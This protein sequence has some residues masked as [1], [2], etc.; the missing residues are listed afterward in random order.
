MLSGKPEDETPI[1]GFNKEV[2]D[3]T[4][5]PRE[6]HCLP[7]QH[8]AA[9]SPSWESHAGGGKDYKCGDS[10]TVQEQHIHGCHHRHHY[11]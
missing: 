1:E 2:S 7:H 8:L 10:K 4:Y 9:A 3:Q 5:G 6:S 11:P